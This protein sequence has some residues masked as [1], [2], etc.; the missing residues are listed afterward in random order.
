MEANQ[1]LIDQLR[2]ENAAL[3]AENSTLRDQLSSSE[4]ER[5][6]V[7][8]ELS[9][10]TDAS[11]VLR[12][13]RDQLQSKVDQLQATVNRLT[14]MVWGRRSEK[15]RYA[16]GQQTLFSLQL[17]LEEL[18]ERREEI[19]TADEVLDEAAERELLA[20]LLARR[21]RRREQRLEERGREEFPEHLERRYVKL[22]LDEEVKQ[23]LVLLDVKKFEQMCFERPHVYIKVIERYEYVRPGQ[24]DAGV[25]AEPTP[26]TIL[27]RVK[28][29][30][31]VIAA[32]LSM[33]LNFHQPTYRQQDIFAQAGFS[34]SR[35]TL[36]D[37]FN[38]SVV[39][40]EALFDEMWR[41]LLAQ[42]I[43][44]GDDTRVRLLTRGALSDEQLEKLSKRSNSSS[45]R[46]PPGSV[47]SYAWLYTGL[48]GMAPYNIFHW[49]LTHEDCWID[50]HL[51]TFRGV[52]VGDATGPNARLEQRSN[53]RLIHAGCNAH[54]RREF[55]FA[56]K[57]H[58]NEAAK[59]VTYYALLNEI[60]ERGK[61]VS[62]AQRLELRQREAVPIWNA[63][64]QWLDSDSLKLVL[65]KSPLGK[66]LT[67]LRNQWDS[68]QRYLQDPRLP[69]DNNQSEQ[70]IRPFVIGRRNWT[71]LGHP[72][73]AAGRLKLFSI[74]SSAHRH[75]VML[76]DYF[77]EVL[78]KLA[79]AQQKDPTLLQPGSDYLQALLPDNWAQANPTL[80]RHDRRE[81]REDVA[82]AT[83]IRRLQRR[84]EERQR[85]QSQAADQQAPTQA[86]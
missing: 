54:A 68:L 30:F 57:T 41:R 82:E 39:V 62:D 23:G 6:Q 33:K 78:A 86:G 20:K 44:L 77:E 59:A 16:E 2:A 42:P 61:L 51:E 43:I 76:H 18:A 73:A 3:R 40:V 13:D 85:E 47:T 15:R 80:V 31:S 65:P 81:E 67:Y 1:D 26:L 12:E 32:A 49:S 74:A 28:Y 25:F 50:Q 24:P 79:H 4:A 14:D 71:F 9:A 11:H 22:D 35:S 45:G 52:F 29:D 7:Q 83:R 8:A 55:T 37:L 66:A 5:S 56:E 64:R 48:D 46:G 53:G 63:F 72:D 60:E 34:L 36:N 10:L 38:Y 84:L 19:I 70:T 27:P 69:I 75:H 58:P 17:S 21:K